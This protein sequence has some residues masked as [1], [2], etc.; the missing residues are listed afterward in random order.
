LIAV[1][2]TKKPPE[3]GFFI[4]LPSSYRDKVSATASWHLPGSDHR[5]TKLLRSRC[6][7]RLYLHQL[8]FK[9]QG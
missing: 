8:D 7:V 1:L 6:H 3:G 9:N 5:S 2:P 4:G